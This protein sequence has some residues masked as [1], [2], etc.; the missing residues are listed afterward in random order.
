MSHTIAR[1]HHPGSEH[2][3][4]SVSVQ[5]SYQVNSARACFGAVSRVGIGL[6]RFLTLASVKLLG[7]P[8]A[9]HILR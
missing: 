2:Q 3:K 7:E 6:L 5:T 8:Y 4:S 9:Y 1:A